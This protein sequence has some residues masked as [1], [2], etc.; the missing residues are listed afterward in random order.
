M[1]TKSA[2]SALIMLLAV[3]CTVGP[4]Y[5]LPISDAPAQWSGNLSDSIASQNDQID[6][7]WRLFHDAELD[8]LIE[9]AVKANLDLRIAESRVRQARAQQGFA[10]A[11][12]WPT[13]N[14]SGSYARQK[15]SENQPILGSLPKSSN[16]PFEN[17]VYKAGF[18]ASW[19]IDIFGGKRRAME[20]ATAE[21]TATE[22]GR[23][24]VMVT[25]LSEVARYYLQTRG[26]Q[27]QLSILQNQIKAQEETVKI[28]RSRVD[29]GSAAEL[30]L[31]RAL[32]LLASIRSQ[33][34]TIE[35]SIHSLI[36][37]LSVLLAKNPDALNAELSATAAI[38]APPPHVPVGLPSD[39]LLR[40][41]DVLRAERLLAVETA[42]IGQVK[43]ELFPKFSLTGSVG[44][45]SISASDFFL[46]G[47]RTWSIGP[48]VQWRI[49][50]AGRVLAN[51]SAQT[52]A[53]NQALL[54]YQ[55]IILTSFE[56]VET[57]L[58]SYAKEQEHYRLL[59]Q[60]VSANQKAVELANQRYAKGWAGYL[61][62]LDAQR[63]LYL[64]Q[65]EWV[66]SER[67]VT[68]NLVALYKALGGGWETE[69]IVP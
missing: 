30:E 58:V 44:A 39:L 14:A 24:D 21:L 68:L 54:N 20:A 3:G 36:Y 46:P 67:I 27:R 12:F 29:H 11:D 25:L 41:P 38:P 66:R 65:D 69:K 57:A 31:Q 23:R 19:E 32:A 5:Q 17:D 51:L 55:K 42:R 22:Y 9:R 35:T 37:H 28:T 15:Q 49:F 47:S 7:W 26:A 1:K 4:D 61:D 2:I 13:L 45:T 56:E 48:T 53:Q 62:L 18:D 33:V 40:R 63:A 8:S 50:D 52:E 59:E 34:P 64:S 43:A 16:I 60:E 6:E 10:E